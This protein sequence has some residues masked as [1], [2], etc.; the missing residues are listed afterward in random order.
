MMAI[1]TVKPSKTGHGMY[2]RYRPRRRTPAS[3]I[4]SPAMML[5]A[6]TASTP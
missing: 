6:K 4:M 2:S 5:T 3:T 1:P